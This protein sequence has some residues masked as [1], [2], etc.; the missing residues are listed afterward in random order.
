MNKNIIKLVTAV[1]IAC[2]I[3]TGCA[4][5]EPER[6][7]GNPSVIE[8]RPTEE[9]YIIAEQ[10]PKTPDKTAK[11]KDGTIY[12]TLSIEEIIITQKARVDKPAA[13][14]MESV[15]MQ[16]ADRHIDTYEAELEAIIEMDESLFPMETKVDY[17]VLR[18]DGRAISIKEEILRTN[19]GNPAGTT[20]FIYNF[21]PVTGASIATDI[22]YKAGDKASL[23]D[24]DSKMFGK[25]T[26]KYG[27][28]NIKYENLRTASYVDAAQDSWYFTEGGIAVYFAAGEI[29]DASLG[30][31][32]IEYA[33]DELPEFA[34][35]YFN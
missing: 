6:T 21:N 7:G 13:Q 32:E 2:A 23:D 15:F 9:H 8:S 1:T 10:M 34:Q 24:A 20:E 35:K 25:L 12:K 31:L 27:E 11:S 19:A 22:F 30:R 3:I 26:A 18:N 4:D 5:K 28:E 33:K 14:K 16:A 29:A 17:T